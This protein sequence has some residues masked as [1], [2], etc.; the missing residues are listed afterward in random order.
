MVFTAFTLLC[1]VSINQLALNAIDFPVLFLTPM[2]ARF[3][4]VFVCIA[5][6][7]TIFLLS[8]ECRSL[9]LG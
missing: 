9:H 5:V 8:I 6:K 4:V 1:N 7:E 3:S 2:H